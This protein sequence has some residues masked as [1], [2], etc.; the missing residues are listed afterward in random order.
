VSLETPATPSQTAPIAL[1]K[2]VQR[3]YGPFI[4]EPRENPPVA[5]VLTVSAISVVAAFILTGVVFATN[6]VDPL[7]AYSEIIRGTLLNSQGLSTAVQRGIPL[8]LIGVGLVLAFRAQFLNIGAEGQMIAGATMGGAVA[9]F[10][11]PLG[12]LTLPVMFA[13]AFA[14]GAFWAFIPAIL[15]LR[16]QINEVITTLMLNYVAAG[17][18]SWLVNG[19][20][21]GKN[22]VG[23][24][25]T[26]DF[27]DAA[28][29]P[30]LG[31]SYIHWPTLLLGL[32]FAVLVAFVLSRT[33]LGFRMRVLGENPVAARYVGINALATV[34]MVALF[35]GGLAGIAGIAEVAAIHHKLLDP[36]Q[37]SQ[38]YGFTAIIVAFLARGNPLGTIITALFLGVI[39]ASGDV[40][41]VSL[42]MPGQTVNVINGLMLFF[43]IG[44]EPLLRYK[45]SLGGRES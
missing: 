32:A 43:L 12:F 18:L 8:L 11:P 10:L 4:V 28:R 15:K 30:L 25:Y 45:I 44:T 21:K 34:M 1:K 20:W 13:V 27:P 29:L 2:T 40:M 42:Q 22:A 38:G 6:G 41:K 31:P 7:R 16:L 39:S 33:R 14:A 35:S 3:R 5:W 36:T 26:A 17:I 37:I 9:L 23:Y 19:P 24:S